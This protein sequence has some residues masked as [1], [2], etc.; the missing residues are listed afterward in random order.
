MYGDDM[1]ELTKTECLSSAWYLQA[2]KVAEFLRDNSD[3]ARE[4]QDYVPSDHVEFVESWL[5]GLRWAGRSPQYDVIPFLEGNPPEGPF[6]DRA[7]ERL[8]Y[9]IDIMNSCEE[10]ENYIQVLESLGSERR[11]LFCRERAAR[12]RMR[13]LLALT[14][15]TK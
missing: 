14:R 6:K 5:E 9:Y 1:T 7:V 12:N 11:R 3:E 2:G 8:E 10:K 13:K 15:Q 4:M